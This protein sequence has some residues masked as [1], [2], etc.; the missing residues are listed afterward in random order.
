VAKVL[1]E[2]GANV[3]AYRPGRNISASFSVK[4]MEKKYDKSL[5][6]MEMT[7]IETNA[8]NV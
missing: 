6:R 7:P 8:L 5:R 1:I 3:N 4:Q 2:L